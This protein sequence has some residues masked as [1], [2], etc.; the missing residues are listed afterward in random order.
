VNQENPFQFTDADL[1]ARLK[2]TEDHF[3]ERKTFGDSK[4][5]LRTVVAFA[6]SAPP[7][8]PCILFIGV[9]DNGDL[10]GI[11]DNLDK[12]QKT[13]GDRLA[14]AYPRIPYFVKTISDGEKQA[15]AVIV[16]GSSSRPHFAGPPFVR[17][18][19]HTHEMSAEE[20]R[21]TFA[22]QNSKAARILEYR[23]KVV[24]VV[25]V[26]PSDG[27][28]TLWPSGVTVAYCD[29]HYVTLQQSPSGKRF[30]FPL[31][32]VRVNFDDERNCL[33]IEILR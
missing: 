27:N 29:Q 1:L 20:Y 25:N 6:N 26:R 21:E 12:M 31:E 9:R 14:N 32:Q 5:W 33:K 11:G 16:S 7:G 22:F 24:T 4:D 8:F 18:G 17:R 2:N 30:S 3:V 23:G 19:S 13:L 15:L 10:Q 28:I